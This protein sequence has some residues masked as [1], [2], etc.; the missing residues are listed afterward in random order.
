MADHRDA[1]TGTGTLCH[2]ADGLKG[3]NG[4]LQ[5]EFGELAREG[6]RIGGGSSG[7]HRSMIA[8]LIAYASGDRARE[9]GEITG[10]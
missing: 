3:T 10:Y 6:G 8:G 4:A 1:A 9:Y 5:R 7:C 2:V